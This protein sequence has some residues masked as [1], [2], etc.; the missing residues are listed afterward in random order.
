PAAINAYDP[1]HPENLIGQFEAGSELEIGSAVVSGFHQVTFHNGEG[2]TI[3]ALC[4]DA[5]IGLTEKKEVVTEKPPEKS[6]E[7]T[8]TPAPPSLPPTSTK[9][10]RVLFIGNSFTFA[11]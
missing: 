3:V 5:D 1:D 10:M 6:P 4:Q 11:H 9:P 8:E 2:Q 7:K